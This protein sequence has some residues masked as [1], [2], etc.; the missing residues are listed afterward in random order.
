MYLRLHSFCRCR[1]C[2]QGVHVGVFLYWLR[3]VSRKM[4]EAVRS[5]RTPCVFADWL[6]RTASGVCRSSNIYRGVSK[7]RA[8]RMAS[9]CQIVDGVL[10]QAFMECR[11]YACRCYFLMD[12][13]AGLLWCHGT[14]LLFACYYYCVVC[15]RF[16][17][18]HT[19]PF[20]PPPPPRW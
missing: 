3:Y 18:A 14:L 7:H 9:G 8:G 5:T 20:P 1:G 6:R 15:T 19:I 4:G 16:V 11:L 13:T 2:V 17:M 10:E 12:C